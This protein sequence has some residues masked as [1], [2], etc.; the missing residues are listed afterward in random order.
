MT[1]FHP[2][3]KFILG[4]LLSLFIIQADAQ[5]KAP[6]LTDEHYAEMVSKNPELKSFL[7]LK[8]Y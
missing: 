1:I 4:T 2:M 8:N 6:C 7:K 5:K 3:K